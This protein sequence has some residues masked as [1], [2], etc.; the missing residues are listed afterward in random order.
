LV[1]Y[2]ITR[3]SSLENVP[4]WLHELKD[5]AD[6]DII[7]ALVGNKNDLEGQREVPTKAGKELAEREAL[8]FFETSAKLSHMVEEAF[9]ELLNQV[10]DVIARNELAATGDE[11]LNTMP[12]AGR[13]IQITEA[14]PEVPQHKRSC[15]SS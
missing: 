10:H 8:L 15:C 3:A 4:K 14:M 11:N 7:V 1:V 12:E 13:S 2:D 6:N 9:Q 5:H